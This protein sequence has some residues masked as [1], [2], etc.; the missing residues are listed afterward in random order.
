MITIFDGRK[1]SLDGTQDEIYATVSVALRDRL[2]EFNTGK[3]LNP[4]AIF[5]KIALHMDRDGWAF[6]GRESMKKS[7]GLSSDAAISSALKHLGKMRVDGHRV[8]A[9]YRT[10]NS[11]GQ[12]SQTL[13][14]VFPDAFQDGLASMPARFRSLQLIPFYGATTDNPPPDNLG[15]DNPP[16]EDVGN[17]EIHE[18]EGPPS[19]SSL[20]PALFPNFP[21]V[22]EAV[23]AESNKNT[24][25]SILIGLYM[26][27]FPEKKEPTVP[28][29]HTMA[30]RTGGYTLL[31]RYLWDV[32]KLQ[33]DGDDVMAY[34]TN[35]HK[36]GGNGRPNHQGKS[37]AA[38]AARR[39]RAEDERKKLDTEFPDGLVVPSVSPAEVAE[40]ARAR[41]AGA[42]A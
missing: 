13:Y 26:Q 12:W 19:E 3:N 5:M 28:Y 16:V 8:L 14:R 38:E 2:H 21:S 31:A 24:K 17:K 39:A 22:R 27:L 32:N 11:E 15:V 23:D 30:G 10:K 25:A 18:E 20:P 33:V 41:R 40:L 35:T 9:I 34:I 4:F 1:I 29:V 42:R 6:P 36:G 37:E 7:T